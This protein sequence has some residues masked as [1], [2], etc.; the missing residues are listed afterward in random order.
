MLKYLLL[1]VSEDILTTNR[2]LLRSS[3]IL[4][5]IFFYKQVVPMALSDSFYMILYK[6]AASTMLKTVVAMSWLQTG[7]IYDAQFPVMHLVFY[8]QVVPMALR[9]S[10]YMILYK[11]AAPTE[12]NFH[13]YDSFSTNRSHLR[14]S[15]SRNASRFLQAGRA[16]GTQGFILHDII[17][18]GRSYGAQFSCIRLVF[19]KQVASTMLNFP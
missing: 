7:R 1:E 6:Q 8:K 5:R 4:I 14:C 13:V 11:Q 2:P 17:Q 3:I 18:T 12:L 10:F 9:D 16:Y 19:Y 15:I